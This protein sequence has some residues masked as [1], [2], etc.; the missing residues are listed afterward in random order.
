[1]DLA[2]QIKNT[3]E[4]IQNLPYLLSAVYAL[5]TTTGGV[6]LLTLFC[7]CFLLIL[8]NR[9]FFSRAFDILERKERRRLEQINE[10]VSSHDAA[11]PETI[12]VVRDLRDAHYF[13]IATGIYA[14]NR[15]RSAF[16]KL[17]QASSHCI[18][19]KHINRARLYIDI[20]ADETITIRDLT[21]SEKL[22]YWYN[23]IVAYGSLFFSVLLFIT[24][25]VLSDTKT[26]TSFWGSFGIS[27]FLV[28]L[29]VFVFFQNMPIYAKD[30]ISKELERLRDCSSDG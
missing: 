3:T 2:S 8:A 10:Y 26:M 4:A 29:A 13:N 11:D 22:G 7:L 28:M 23:Q 30:L 6:V 9:G 15:T 19:W 5:V 17:H 21:R 16:I 20:A 18:A 1:M 27:I 25:F 12:K 24:T 14:E